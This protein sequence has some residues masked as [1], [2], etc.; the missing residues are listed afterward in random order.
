MNFIKVLYV[1]QHDVSLGDSLTNFYS[2]LSLIKEK[3]PNSIIYA[4][5]NPRTYNTSVTNIFLQKGLI[6]FVYPFYIKN[7][8]ENHAYKF[9]LENTK[10]D[11][12]IHN[13]HSEKDV[14]ELTR[15]TF[16][17]GLHLQT[18]ESNFGLLNIF[19]YC[20]V[21]HNDFLKILKKSY[22][23]DYISEFANRTLSVSDKKK[24]CIF[25]GSTRPLANVGYKG[26]QKIIDLTSSLNFHN[27]L[28]GTSTFNLYSKDGIDW[29][30]IYENTY[31]NTTNLIGNNWYKILEVMKKSDIII[32]GPTG[33]AMIPPL[34][35]KNQILI[36]GGDSP[37]MEGCINGYT[38]QE[39]TSKLPCKCVNYP[40]DVNNSKT[41]NIKYN[42]CFVDKNPLCLNEEINVDD[43]SNILKSI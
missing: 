4:V 23:T 28:V 24:V 5:V 25:S 19:E 37:I 18:L 41:D 6:D 8:E 42:K 43:L 21:N 40:C 29:N 36:L 10:F 33:A 13:Q 27:F 3:H 9:I 35:N 11:L 39:Y 1:W 14:L 34:I 22:H 17:T 12:I 26:L 30:C 16:P 7:I 38:N 20:Q 15:K 32:S 2:H 31:E